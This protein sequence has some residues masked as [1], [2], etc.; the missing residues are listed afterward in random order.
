MVLTA[1][2]V[3]TSLAWTGRL[4]PPGAFR[5]IPDYWHQTADWLDRA[6][7]R[8]PHA[9]RVLVVPGAP[10]ATQ[11]WGNSHDEPLQ[12]LGDSPWGVR[13][14]IPL[15]PPQTIRALDSVQ[16][17]F[18]AGRPSA[19]LADTLAR[20]GISY[21]VVRND[22]DPETSRSA[23]PLL[24]HRAIDGSPGLHEGG[25]VRRTG[26]PG[27][28]GGFHH[29]QR[30]A[31]AVPGGGDLPGRRRE[32]NPGAPYLD[33]RRRDGPGRRRARKSLLRLD[34]RRRLLGQ[35]PLGPM[36]LT[37]DAQRA[38]LPAPGRHRH[39]HPGGPR[40][41]LRP[42]RRPLVGDPRGRRSRATP[43]TG[44]PTIRRPAPRTVHGAVD[45]RPDHARRVRRR[46]PPR[47]P[48]SR[49]PPARPRP[50]TA[51]RRPSWVSNS[52]QSAVGQWLQV[53]FD[54]PVT[55][56]TITIT[57]S[58]TAVGAQVRR[59]A[60]LHRQR[61]H[62]AALRRAGQAA[63]GGA[64][65]RRDAVGADHRGRHRRRVL[66][67]AV[68]HH[69]SVR[70]PSTTP[71]DSP[72]R[73]TCAT[74]S[75]VPGAAAGSAVAQWD[76]GSELLGRPAAPTRPT[77]CTARRRWRWPPEEPVN[78]SRTLTVPDPIDGDADGVGAARQGPQPGRPD[79]ASRAPPE[80][81][82]TPT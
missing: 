36:L 75:S 12:V 17:L 23:R 50:S 54:H 65:L 71:R 49:R 11:V 63:D 7:R 40:D 68:R 29:R 35:P 18:A 38:G 74:P 37:A 61:H 80:R 9:G 6:Q 81:R 60:G 31:A 27:H 32:R 5:A 82:A 52:L 16:R 47:C 1:L 72:I 46:T 13:D 20:Q 59:I 55:N 66:R 64:A 2:A 44:C 78:L 33:R 43:S 41:R 73:S 56:A 15:T 42:G 77:A 45:R 39:R 67:R 79:R 8:R 28:A 14:S 53:D 62:H 24:V 3:A 21:V 19:G 30:A 70:S 22:L 69:R 51:T 10:F 58:A 4:T 26:R 25:R 34:E 57:P 48:T 76:L